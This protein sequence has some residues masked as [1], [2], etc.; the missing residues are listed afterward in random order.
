MTKKQRLILYAFILVVLIW[1]LDLTVS[2]RD[3]DPITVRSVFSPFHFSQL[4][5][6]AIT[7]ALMHWIGT[8]FFAKKKYVL[9]CVA[10]LLMIFVFTLLRYTIEEVIYPLVLDGLRNYPEKYGVWRYVLDNIYFGAVCIGV[11]ISAFLL[12]NQVSNQRRQA[13]LLQQNREAE[14]LF[15]RSQV[16]PHFLFN[17]LNNIYSLVY[18]QSPKAPGAMLQLSELMRYILYE[19]KELVSV[20]REWSYIENFIT[21]QKLRFDHDLQLDITV[22][23]DTDKQLIPPYL[24]I[25]FIEN[26]FKHGD[27]RND[28]LHIRL[29]VSSAKMDFEISNKVSNRNKDESGGIGM[30]NVKRRLELLY[31]EKHILT[32]E[33]EDSFYTARLVL[34]F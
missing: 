4:I 14:L 9:F 20:R 22:T 30:D 33:T 28:S 11:G 7:L 26:A 17:T 24:L 2:L 15:L 13:E 27:F 16:N 31:P 29:D 8:R 6:S 23:G 19:K 18:E 1:G 12:D 3:G 25:P 10:S 34:N 21:L 5:Y 32:Y